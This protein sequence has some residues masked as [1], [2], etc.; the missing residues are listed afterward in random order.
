[1]ALA[2]AE[3]VKEVEDVVVFTKKKWY[4]QNFFIT[5]FTQENCSYVVRLIQQ[6]C[7]RNSNVGV[8]YGYRLSLLSLLQTLLLTLILTFSIKSQ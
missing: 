1:M 3:E 5:N 2:R 8:M 4:F 6:G 7:K